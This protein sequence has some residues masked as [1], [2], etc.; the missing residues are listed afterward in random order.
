MSLLSIVKDMF[1]PCVVKIDELPDYDLDIFNRKVNPG[2]IALDMVELHSDLMFIIKC[3]KETEDMY[4]IVCGMSIWDKEDL[5][6]SNGLYFIS[7]HQYKE[8]ETK[9]F[10]IDDAEFKYN[11]KKSTS[12]IFDSRNSE[13]KFASIAAIHSIPIRAR[14]KTIGFVLRQVHTV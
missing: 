3:N 7:K 5:N 14:Q 12:A 4:A 6:Y 2:V 10:V 1:K 11:V 13:Y 9:G 8:I